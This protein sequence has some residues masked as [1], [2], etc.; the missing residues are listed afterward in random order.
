MPPPG[1]PGHLI[2]TIRSPRSNLAR[3]DSQPS[4]AILAIQLAAVTFPA[5]EHA[6]AK[7]PFLLEKP[8]ALGRMIGR[9]GSLRLSAGVTS[10][11]HQPT[12]LPRARAPLRELSLV[13][14]LAPWGHSFT[15]RAIHS[16]AEVRRAP[17]S[18]RP[19]GYR[20]SWTA[21]NEL[22]KYPAAIPPDPPPPPLLGGPFLPAPLPPANS[23]GVFLER[24]TR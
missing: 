20:P 21:R 17:A 16:C 18:F 7:F 23:D 8:Q 3:G 9:V 5:V 24:G 4:R 13:P 1:R 15:A 14:L 2:A 11:S 12:R 10:Q 6:W 22:R 19:H